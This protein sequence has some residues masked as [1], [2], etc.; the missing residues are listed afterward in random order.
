MP[1]DSPEWDYSGNATDTNGA[2]RCPGCPLRDIRPDLSCVHGLIQQSVCVTG[3][4]AENTF[5]LFRV[6]NFAAWQTVN[7]ATPLFPTYYVDGDAEA[8]DPAVGP[9]EGD[10]SYTGPYY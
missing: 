2:L 3:I 8:H 1:V 4:Q 5:A 6:K 9:G 7:D 10:P